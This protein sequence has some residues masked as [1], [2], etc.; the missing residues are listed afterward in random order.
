[1]DDFTLNVW[2][3]HRPIPHL[4]LNLPLI[5]FGAFWATDMDIESS[6]IAG[7]TMCYLIGAIFLLRFIFLLI[8]WMNNSNRRGDYDS[9]SVPDALSAVMLIVM[10]IMISCASENDYAVI[11]EGYLAL[12]T[13]M[14][15]FLTVDSVVYTVHYIIVKRNDPSSHS[16]DDIIG[17]IEDPEYVELLKKYEA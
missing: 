14:G 9:L 16:L 4:F 15:I 5:L 1:M 13:V 17:G 6:V 8:G 7:S 10:G 3:K 11:T 2:T 12:A